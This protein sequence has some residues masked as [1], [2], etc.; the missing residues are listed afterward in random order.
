[1]PVPFDL[2]GSARA[3]AKLPCPR[4]RTDWLTLEPVV[5]H[6]ASPICRRTCSL[7]LAA[8]LACTDYQ[9]TRSFTC[10]LAA[11]TLARTAK[12]PRSISSTGISSR[13]RFSTA[14]AGLTCNRPSSHRP[15]GVSQHDRLEKRVAP[16]YRL[17]W[18][19]S[20]VAWARAK[21]TGDVDLG[22]SLMRDWLRRRVREAPVKNT[23]ETSRKA[24]RPGQT[25]ALTS[26]SEDRGRWP[27]VV[28]SPPANC[29]QGACRR[30]WARRSPA[31]SVATAG[32]STTSC[33]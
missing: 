32:R 2:G 24:R 13:P 9:R 11:A 4:K 14:D 30:C 26:T 16:R 22:Q 28:D 15:S 31:S 25:L 29:S 12:S 1:M 27:F 20:H 8:R 21:T 19:R 33:R 5:R 23:D 17:P 10:S 6:Q 7:S 3:P 18:A